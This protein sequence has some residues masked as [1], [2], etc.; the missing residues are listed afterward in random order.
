MSTFEFNSSFH[1]FIKKCPISSALILVNTLVLLTILYKGGFNWTVLYELGGIHGYS[2]KSGEYERLLLGMFLH[3]DFIHYLFNT[4]FGIL[5]I[6]AGLERLIGSLK[7]FIVYFVTG[8][9]S[10]YLVVLLTNPG[11]LTVGS[12]GAIY[13][14]FGVFLYFILYKPNTISYHSRA[15]IR[16]LL[17]INLIFSFIFPNISLVGHLG[18]LI[19][20]FLLSF[21]L[22]FNIPNRN[23]YFR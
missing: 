12:S 1:D 11:N 19:S 18:G 6:S 2:V 23:P 13:G 8:I 21:I 9:A 7:F 10:S 4:L 20:G 22:F 17:V 16:N 14:V 3:W 5:I 15:Y